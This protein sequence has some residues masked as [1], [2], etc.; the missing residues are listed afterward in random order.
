MTKNP[1]VWVIVEL[2]GNKVPETYH[3]VLA[4]WYGGFASGDS[5]QLSSGVERIVKN[6][7]VYEIYNTSGSIYRCHE[8]TERLSGMT[9]NVLASYTAGNSEEL[10]MTQ[11][12]L[13]NIHAKYLSA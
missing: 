13:E 6:D 10:S 12:R 4:G 3:R 1:D 7:K 2:A 9:A 5:W 11:V 8:D